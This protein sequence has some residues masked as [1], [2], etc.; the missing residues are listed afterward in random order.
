MIEIALSTATQHCPFLPFLPLTVSQRRRRS[1][2]DAAPTSCD[3][4]RHAKPDPNAGGARSPRPINPSKCS[5]SVVPA[6]RKQTLARLS[7]PH[8]SQRRNRAPSSP[9]F[10]ALAFLGRL[11]WE[12]VDGFV[13]QASE[14][15]AQFA[16]WPAPSSRS[17]QLVSAQIT[18]RPLRFA[19]LQCEIFICSTIG[20]PRM[21]SCA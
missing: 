10:R 5:A 14:K 16:N 21:S 19:A 6:S 13:M 20:Q 1:L 9:R 3:R 12:R 17:L 8:R 15:P 18:R 2:D 11:S 4:R 7:N